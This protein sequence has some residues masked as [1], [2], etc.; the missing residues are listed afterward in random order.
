[1]PFPVRPHLTSDQQASFLQGHPP[2]ARGS[3]VVPEGVVPGALEPF[4]GSFNRLSVMCRSSQ[5]PPFPSSSPEHPR[6]AASWVETVQR[7]A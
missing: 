1:M 7:F 3:T 2:D 4:G 5:T 6:A